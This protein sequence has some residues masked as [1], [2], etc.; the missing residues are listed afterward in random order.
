MSRNKKMFL[1]KA[2]EK[3]AWLMGSWWGISLH[4][5]WFS[6]WVILR[7]DMNLLTLW[8][9]LEAIFLGIFLLMASN[10]AEVERDRR[11][12]IAQKRQMELVRE[13]VKLDKRADRRQL[14]M[15]K[16]LREIKKEVDAVKKLV[17]K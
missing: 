12:V 8:V 5:L 7:F 14:E 9:S 3:I 11:E 16:E 15:L 4:T 6:I 2:T 10:R 1:D 17:G 13:D